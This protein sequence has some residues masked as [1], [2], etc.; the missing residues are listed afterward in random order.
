[1]GWGLCPVTSSITPSIFTSLLCSERRGQHTVE[2]SPGCAVSTSQLS[3]QP[4]AHQQRCVYTAHMAGMPPY[5]LNA[6]DKE[7]ARGL[8]RGFHLCKFHFPNLPRT[9]LYEIRGLF[10]F[11]NIRVL[12]LKL[13]INFILENSYVKTT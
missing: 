11:A 13:H 4:A 9:V 10:S 6:Q 5:F 1:M 2:D 8:L 7:L 12:S 3:T